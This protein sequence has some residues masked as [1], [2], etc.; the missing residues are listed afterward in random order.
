MEGA[1]ALY[2][3]FDAEIIDG[4]IFV[5]NDLRTPGDQRVQEWLEMQADRHYQEVG[6][7]QMLRDLGVDP[8]MEV[9]GI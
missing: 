5:S 9:V 3:S 4:I 6:K 1:I 7:E 8:D 2:N